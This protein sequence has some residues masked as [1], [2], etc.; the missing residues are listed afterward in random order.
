[1]VRR[2][3]DWIVRGALACSI[4]ISAQAGLRLWAAEE[5]A[6]EKGAALVESETRLRED[7][8]VLASDEYEGRGVGTAGLD[9]AADYVAAEFK[10][11][12]LNTNVV[13]GGPFQATLRP[14]RGEPQ[15]HMADIG[16]AWQSDGTCHGVA[17]FDLEPASMSRCT[18]RLPPGCE[19]VQLTIDGEPGAPVRTRQ[20]Q[21]DIS[22]GGAGTP[23]RM[24]VLFQGMA[25]VPDAGG[26]VENLLAGVVSAGRQERILV[27]GADIPL[28][29]PKAVQDLLERCAE[30]SAELYY[31]IVSQDTMERQYPGSG[32][33][34]RHFVEGRYCGGDL[35]LVSPEV[36]SRNI[37]FLEQMSAQRKTAWGMVKLMG[38]GVIVGF[39]TK[40]LSIGDLER[41]G[42]KILGCQVKAIVSPCPELAMDV[43]GPQHLE[44]ARRCLETRRSIETLDSP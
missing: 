10:K 6:A 2:H 39:L 13:D 27:C 42:S 22:L 21:W 28:L 36:V 35:M 4:A 34:F 19:L 15:L 18:L 25:P 38:L 44:I 17:V 11:A 33:S 12:G 3:L 32:R 43:D 9:K 8:G 31:P 1:M 16:W 26:L 41:R 7:V 30:R 29:T 24:E 20:D 37:P 23:Q 5:K 40:R 14:F